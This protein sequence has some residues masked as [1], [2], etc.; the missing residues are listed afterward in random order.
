MTMRAGWRRMRTGARWT[1][2]AVLAT[3]LALGICTVQAAAILRFREPAPLVTAAVGQ[4]VTSDGVTYRVDAFTV[5]SQLPAN[6]STKPVRAMARA[7]LIQTIVTVRVDDP[8]RDLTTIDCTMTLA[9][10]DG[11]NWQPSDDGYDVLGPD[12]VTC[13]SSEEH[14]VKVGRP[15]QV[16][17][18]FEIPASATDAVTLQLGSGRQTL[19][20]HR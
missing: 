20:F 7:K 16:G 9:A 15:F 3:V 6:D 11:R 10:A 12:R 17:A 14:P 2:A 19:E 1:I 8:A 18:V 13:S 4:P 5:A